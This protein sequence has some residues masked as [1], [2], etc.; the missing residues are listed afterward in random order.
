MVIVDHPDKEEKLVHKESKAPGESKENLAEMVHLDQLVAKD[1]RVN[2]VRLEILD[3][4]EP[5]VL[6]DNEVSPD[7]VAQL[8][9]KVKKAL[10][11]HKVNGEILVQLDN[12][13]LEDHLAPKE[14]VVNKVPAVVQ[15]LLVVPEREEKQEN[16]VQL[17]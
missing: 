16:K 2:V 5:R 15:D 1:P 3:P 6:R 13:E 11:V 4:L 14:R 9:N 12:K 17:D 7:L 10:K 8:E